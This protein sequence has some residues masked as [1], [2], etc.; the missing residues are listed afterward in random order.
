MSKT[1][2]EQFADLVIEWRKNHGQGLAT[3]LMIDLARY[4]TAARPTF[5]PEAFADACG[6][7]F[8][9]QW[10]DELRGDDPMTAMN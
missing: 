1:L 6:I 2:W 7:D 10:V 9:G 5:A 4:S 8:G 3:L